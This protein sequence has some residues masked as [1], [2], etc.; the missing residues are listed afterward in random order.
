MMHHNDI[1]VNLAF[2][3]TPMTFPMMEPSDM[4]LR[5]TSLY[6]TYFLK[7][8]RRTAFPTRIICDSYLVV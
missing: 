2:C 3:H 8:S 1:V 4:L 6:M 7:T 5:V